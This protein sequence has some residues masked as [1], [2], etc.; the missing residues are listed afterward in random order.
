MKEGRRQE[1]QDNIKKML[2][3]GV[4]EAVLADA[5]GM[6]VEEIRKFK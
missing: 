6:S 3:K 1:R 4:D 2:A 5:F